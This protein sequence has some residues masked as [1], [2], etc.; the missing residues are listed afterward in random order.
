MLFDTHVI[1]LMP[2]Y[3]LISVLT[4]NCNQYE[5]IITVNKYEGKF[6]LLL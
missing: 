3:S 1:I 5:T 6:H 2:N 4:Y